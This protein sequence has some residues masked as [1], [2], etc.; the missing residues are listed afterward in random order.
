MNA[1]ADEEHNEQM[2]RVPEQL[3]VLSANTR[4]GSSVHKNHAQDDNV[5][6]KSRKSSPELMVMRVRRCVRDTL[7]NDVPYGKRWE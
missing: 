5:A 6:S 2:M 1:N 4:Y 3:E 7:S